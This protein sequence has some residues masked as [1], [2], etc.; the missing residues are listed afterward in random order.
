MDD[1]HW[2]QPSINSIFRKHKLEKLLKSECHCRRCHPREREDPGH[3]D[4]ISTEP[5]ALL[6]AR[7]RPRRAHG[8]IAAKAGI[9]WPRLAFAGR[10]TLRASGAQANRESRMGLRILAFS[11]MTGGAYSSAYALS[12]GWP[13]FTPLPRQR[14]KGRLRPEPS[15][16]PRFR[17]PSASPSI[18]RTG[19]FPPRYRRRRRTRR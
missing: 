9:Q 11:R 8:S 3:H 7:T 2:R 6:S 13:E 18:R 5:A 14:E 1:N 12:R 17:R 16:R 19:T 10:G 15:A 4:R